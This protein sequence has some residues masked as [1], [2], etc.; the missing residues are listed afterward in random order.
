MIVILY[1]NTPFGPF[2]DNADA[3]AFA[4]REFGPEDEVGWKAKY[5][6][7]PSNAYLYRDAD[8]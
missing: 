6:I 5:I 3:W 4:T 8:K 2:T 7:H 1:K